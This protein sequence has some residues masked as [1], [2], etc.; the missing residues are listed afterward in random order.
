M[1]V[2]TRYSSK[3]SKD[4]QRILELGNR[5]D[6]LAFVTRAQSKLYQLQ[7]DATGTA[8]ASKLGK[9]ASFLNRR[10]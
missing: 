4:G 9:A 5:P 2:D 6:A 8:A 10:T 1:T 7:R 3:V